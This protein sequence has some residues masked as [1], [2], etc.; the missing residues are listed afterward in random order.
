MTGFTRE[1]DR[2]TGKDRVH[3]LDLSKSP[4]AMG[5]ATAFNQV[6]EGFDVL[7]FY[8]S[9]SGQFFEFF[10]HNNFLSRVPKSG[11]PH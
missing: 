9:R 2:E 8:L 4:T 10:S 7:A 1:I 5:A 6:G 3:G 11:F